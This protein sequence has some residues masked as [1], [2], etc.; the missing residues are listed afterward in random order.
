MR[1]AQEIDC[2]CP[3][4]GHE[5]NDLLMKSHAEVVAPELLMACESVLDCLQYLQ[6]TGAAND[7]GTKVEIVKLLAVIARA[8]G[9]A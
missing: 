2:K 6:T 1:R 4:C 9:E 5:Y 3:E 7:A 8:K